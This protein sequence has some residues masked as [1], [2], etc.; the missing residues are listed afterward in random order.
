MTLT[1]FLAAVEKKLP[2]AG[3]ADIERLEASLGCRLP[4]EYRAFL[5]A[6]NGGYVGGLLWFTGPTPSGEVAD[7][8]VHHVGGFRQEPH[9]SLAWA[10]EVYEGRIPEDLLWIMDDPFGNALCLGIQ[11][12]HTGKVFFWDHE[13]E[14]GDDWDGRVETAGNL[15][16]LA[17]SFPAFVAGL[18][19]N[20]NAA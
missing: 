4:E 7:A 5:A 8:G 11:G 18:H 20:E 12:P 1:E 10:R 15:Q 19:R 2:P 16:L 6:C 13:N 14:P 17:N 9:F 3:Q